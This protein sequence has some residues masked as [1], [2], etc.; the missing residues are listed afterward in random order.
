MR[1]PRASA[2]YPS[3]GIGSPGP[4]DQTRQTTRL[5]PIAPAEQL[6][7]GWCGFLAW[8]L[9]QTGEAIV[10]ATASPREYT[11]PGPPNALAHVRGG[12]CNGPMS[13]PEQ[14][15]DFR[16]S[17][18]GRR[19]PG[20]TRSPARSEG[21]REA[22]ASECHLWSER[23]EGFGGPAQ[24][25]PTIAQCLNGG[26]R[27]L[28]LMCRRCETRASL[29]LEAIRR[30]RHTPIWKLEAAL[31]CRSCRTPR[32]AP[33]VHMIRLTKE[34]EIGLTFGCI[35]TMIDEPAPLSPLSRST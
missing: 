21:A 16:R 1:A 23:M 8:R 28:E 31:R 26:Y 22:D 7:S 3:D 2:T 17:S 11:R 13:G 32:Y 35:R 18:Q 4:P 33:P 27:W 10:S 6:S 25:S 30:P 34:R 9:K 29:P 15:A 24:P 12:R 5:R 14:T 20:T 19:S